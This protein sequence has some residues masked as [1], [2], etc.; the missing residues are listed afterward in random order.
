ME[1]IMTLA[2]TYYLLVTVLTWECFP[3][4]QHSSLTASE[5]IPTKE[6]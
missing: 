5:I 2:V 4:Y 3:V 6:H 1:E